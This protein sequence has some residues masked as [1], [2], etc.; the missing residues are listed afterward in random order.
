MV[1]ILA[2]CVPLMCSS[3]FAVPPGQSLELSRPVRSGIYVGIG[4]RAGIWETSREHS[5][6]GFIPLNPD[7][8][9]LRFHVEGAVLPAETLARTL[10]SA[11][12]L[13]VYVGDAFQSGNF[14]VPCTNAIIAWIEPT[15]SGG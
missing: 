11:L 4:T 10:M 6:H 1:L 15:T 3:Y 5:R 8:F 2:C 12:S 14:V 9:H 7:D 13:H